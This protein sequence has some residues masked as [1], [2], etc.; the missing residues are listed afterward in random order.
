MLVPEVQAPW[1]KPTGGELQAE[2]LDF[3]V[4]HSWYRATGEHSFAQI[5]R[6]Q[7]I[8][9]RYR[10]QLHNDQGLLKNIVT[11]ITGQ[12]AHMLQSMLCLLL[13]QD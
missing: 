13:D 3:N 7:I 6:F 11:I 9:G 12:P 4:V 1:K 5:K 8:G 10:G 2:Q